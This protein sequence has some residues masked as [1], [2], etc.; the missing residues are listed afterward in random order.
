MSKKN[1]DSFDYVMIDINGFTAK[2]WRSIQKIASELMENGLFKKD[3]FKCS[4]AA[5]VLWIDEG[6]GQYEIDP[7][8]A[9]DGTLFN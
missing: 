1:S 4:I 7:D 2:D 3:P 5:F 6:N 9:P 8:P